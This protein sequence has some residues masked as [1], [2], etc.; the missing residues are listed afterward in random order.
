[1]DA[2]PKRWIWFAMLALAGA[3]LAVYHN[4][5]S[6]PFIFDDIPSIADNPTIRELRTAANLDVSPT[7]RGAGV[8]GRPM[9]NL[10]LAL[11]HALGGDQVWGYHVFNLLLHI[12]AGL[13]LFGIVRRTLLGERLIGTWGGAALPLAFAIALL[14]LVH[15]LQTESV[16]C[17]IQRTESMLG[18]FYLLALYGFI[19]SAEPGAGRGGAMTAVAACLLGALTKEVIVTLPVIALLYDRAFVS[20]TFREAWRRRARLYLALASS[21]V[22]VGALVL[23]AESRGGTVGFGHGVTGWEYALTQCRALV[24]YLKLSFWPNPLVLDYGTTVVRDPLAVLPQGLLILALLAAT[25]WALRRRPFDTA[26]GRPMLGF[27]GA[28]FFVILAPSSSVVPLIT[29][30]IGLGETP[31]IFESLKRRTHQCKV[32]IAPGE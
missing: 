25:A 32:M 20:G 13:A 19:R 27:V 31:E 17:V 11:N 29:Q 3:A 2:S 22:V 28:F 6:A 21:W 14:W 18:L 23:R 4:T 30:T 26:Q 24:L 10:S 8:A 15:P 1:M 7:W 12:G 5:F 16:T 9:V